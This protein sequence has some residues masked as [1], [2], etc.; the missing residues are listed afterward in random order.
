MTSNQDPAPTSARTR[1]N[2]TFEE[3]HTIRGLLG[4]LQ[5]LDK[6]DQLAEV[7]T[8]LLVLLPQHFAHE[9]EEDGVFAYVRQ[10]DPRRGH[11]LDRFVEEH[12]RF[13]EILADLERSIHVDGERAVTLARS[14]GQALA[15][16]EAQENEVV[17]SALY[18][19]IGDK[20]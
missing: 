13:N 6:P 2:D 20:D 1:A 17:M 10:Q 19:E 11:D 5:A 12:A 15:A 16:H 14:L 8:Q 7:V 3:H 18:D 4:A 9:E